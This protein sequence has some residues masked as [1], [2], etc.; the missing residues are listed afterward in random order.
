MIKKLGNAIII[1]LA[2]IGIIV[3]VWWLST[4]KFKDCKKVGHS[5]FYCIMDMGN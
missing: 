4:Y 2:I 3:S 5:T 1:G